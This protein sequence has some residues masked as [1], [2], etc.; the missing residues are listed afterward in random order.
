VLLRAIGVTQVKIGRVT[1]TPI[2][3]AMLRVRK[4]LV[5]EVTL[6]MSMLVR[7][8]VLRMRKTRTPE[9]QRMFSTKNPRQ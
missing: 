5:M 8:V 6:R 3:E 9:L 1:K 4:K 2:M 7:I